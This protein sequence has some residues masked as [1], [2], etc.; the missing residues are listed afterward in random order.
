MGR[1]RIFYLF[2]LVLFL[3]S[4]PSFLKAKELK[5]I[6]IYSISYKGDPQA[7]NYLNTYLEELSSQALNKGLDIELKSLPFKKALSFLRTGHVY[8]IAHVNWFAIGNQVSVDWELKKIGTKE[9]FYF[10]VTG[11]KDNLTDIAIQTLKHLESIAVGKVLIEDIKVSGNLNI[12][13]DLILSVV[14]LKPGDI[15][16]LKKVDESLKAIYNLGYFENVEAYL[17]EG[18]KG[19]ILIFKVKERP[20]LKDAEFKGN[21]SV[22]E[23]VLFKVVKLKKGEIVTPE[24]LDKAIS[25]IISYYEQKGFQGTKVE[26]SQKKVSPTQVKLI[27]HIKEGQK[28]YIKKIEFVG[29][30]AFS[31][32]KLKEFLS[33]S[34]K[35]S[36][37]PVRKAIYYL[38]TFLKPGSAAEPGV[39]NMMYLKRDLAKIE[40]FYKNHGY[41]DVKIGEPSVKEEKDGVV[42]TIPIEEGP[43]YKVGS[44]KVV[45]SLFPQSF[46]EKKLTLKPGDTFS[47]MK[48][49][50]D[51]VLI[52]HLFADHGY[53]Y[54]KVKTLLEKH[55]NRKIINIT[56]KVYKGPVVYINRIEIT[57]NTKTRDKVIRR[58]IL[59]AEKWPYSAKRIEKSEERIKRLGFFEDVQIKQEKAAKED[60]L[61]L[62]VKVK[63]MLTGSFGIGGGYSTRDKFYFM[64]QISERNFLGKGQRI[65]LSFR[66]SSKNIRYSLDFFDPYFRDTRYSLGWSIYDYKTEYTD[67]TKKSKGFSIRTGYN[68]SL[69][70]SGY[71]GYRFDYTDLEDV[72]NDTAQVIKDSED[73]HITSAVQAGIKYDSRNHFFLPTKGWY[74]SLDCEYAG[75]GG[76]SNYF[77]ITGTHHVFFPLFKT[78]GHIKLGYGY[79]TEGSGK[80]IPVF[81][82]FYLGGI[83]S[84]RGYKYGDISPVDPATGDKIG[85]TRM[86]YTQIED[87]F[88][89]VKSINLMGVVFYDMGEVWDKDSGFKSSEIKKSIGIGVR[90]LSPLGPMRLEWG[91]NIDRKAGE[92]KSNFNFIIGGLF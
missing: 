67:F 48:L 52:T 53:A 32:D 57:G 72:A 5:T 4:F 15:L 3:L 77:K 46:I 39:Y 91:Y 63:E 68:F 1:I 12:G 61:N 80:K 78:T 18:E 28:K 34:E 44:V 79:L 27:F 56:Y 69:N 36:F 14:K 50:E 71:V 24:L 23:G 20:I 83:D 37:M 33:V 64:S 40:L 35:S 6:L 31:D 29:N 74:H 49:K 38:K 43:C 45:Q 7:K 26:V 51:K 8:L 42:I 16:D 87:I 88:P 54:A 10:Y 41:L 70:L 76:D 92:D 17:E 66:M 60:E 19:A 73:I 2:I 58:Q 21:K 22:K 25:N 86:F 30:H 9:P 62:K 89:I 13:P 47:L 55:P 65:S 90:W 81:E 85:G 59:I 75:L 84:V 82:R 11:S